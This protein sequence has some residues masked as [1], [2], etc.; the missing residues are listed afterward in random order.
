M[1]HLKSF[2]IANHLNFEDSPSVMQLAPC[3]TAALERSEL[4]SYI[5]IYS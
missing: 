4:H 5:I 1:H 2:L 3:F